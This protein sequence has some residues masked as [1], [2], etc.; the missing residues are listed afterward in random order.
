MNDFAENFNNEENM[1]MLKESRSSGR[2]IRGKLD[3][4]RKENEIW[5]IFVDFI[6]A[7]FMEMLI[8]RR[9]TELFRDLSDSNLSWSRIAVVVSLKS[10]QSKRH[11]H[12]SGQLAINICYFK[13][14]IKLCQFK[15]NT[16]LLS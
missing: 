11:F 2:K 13:A 14:V 3:L 15:T 8:L 16:T 12:D 9:I 6:K 4:Q 10:S 1:K 7:V 5:R